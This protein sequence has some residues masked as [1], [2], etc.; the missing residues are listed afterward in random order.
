MGVT[1]RGAPAPTLRVLGVQACERD[2]SLRLP[3]RFGVHTLD[4]AAQAVVRVT[5]QAQGRQFCGYAAEV[6]LPKWFDKSPAL[7]PSDNEEQLRTS[8]RLAAAAYRDRGASTAF[9]LFAD[10]YGALAQEAAALQLPPLVGAFG[11]ALLDRAIIDGLCRHAGCSF[12]DAL[13]A[14]LVGMTR[15]HA[16]SD[17]DGFDWDAFLASRRIS[18]ALQARHTVG[19]LD[20]LQAQRPR[21]AGGLPVSLQESIQ[22]YGLRLF[23]IKLSGDVAWDIDRLQAVAAVLDKH[24]KS[25]RVTLDGNEQFEGVEQFLELWH[26]I[27]ALPALRQLAAAALFIEQPIARGQALEAS[28]KPLSSIRPVI[29]DESDATLDSFVLAQERGYQGVSSKSC[30]GIYKSL[31]NAARCAMWNAAAQTQRHF[32]SA[33]DLIIQ[34]GLSLQQDLLLASF[35]GLEHVERNGHHYVDGFAATGEAEARAF[36]AAHPDLYGGSPPRLLIRDGAIALGSSARAL[37]Y[38][39]T[40]VPDTSA[41]RPM[42]G[43]DQLAS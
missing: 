33:E 40:V 20:A 28:V 39:T 21:E 10:G 12:E 41:D 23:K 25:Y 18:P 11:A 7:T 13:R 5:L 34:P 2:F 30:K 38:A 15:H 29:I 43:L 31:T 24:C 35:L 17:L 26:A 1:S 4:R 32:M 19:M 36:A 27:A 42:P 16:V 22:H 3:F 6:L 14:N 37:G 9:G 8:L